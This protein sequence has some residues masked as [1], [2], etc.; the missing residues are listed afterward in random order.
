MP[1][2]SP[3]RA[4]R[5]RPAPTLELPPREP[6]ESGRA[7]A[8]R[9]LRQNIIHLHLRPGQDVSETEI[10]AAFR[11]SRTPVREAFIRLAGEGLLDVHAQKGSLVSRIDTERAGEARFL[12]LVVES[13]ILRE[14][15]RAFPAPLRFEL[16]A[17][18]EMQRFCRKERGYE[19]MYHLDNEFHR[20]LYL[21]CGKERLWH[22]I[23]KFDGDL[24]RLRI[25]RLSTRIS[26]DSVIDEH[27]RILRRVASGRP[28]GVD[29]LVEEHLT[30]AVYDTLLVR[31]P[32]YFKT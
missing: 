21:G 27:A 30:T 11:L 31:Y 23:K 28:D 18:L 10:A 17:N 29:A 22:H 15:A 5:P 16:A 24:D 13:A 32:D 12:R 3:V 2:A 7:W 26:W 9:A 8:F 6:A 19:R 4:S 14:A 25:L 1:T 20:L